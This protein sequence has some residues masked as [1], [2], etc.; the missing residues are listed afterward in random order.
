MRRRYTSAQF[1]DLIAVIY[2]LMPDAGLTCDVIVGF[3]G[4]TEPQF[5]ETVRLCE[6]A[7]FLKIHAFPYSQRTGTLAARM[8]DDV[9]PAEKQR[10]VD[11]LLRL[12]ERQGLDF[13]SRFAGETVSVLVEQRDR[14]TGQL[15]GLTG[16]YLRVHFDGPDNLRGHILPV[17]IESVAS[18]GAAGVLV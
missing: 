17:Q 9:P 12:S 11:V 6:E 8:E 15:S 1:R 3:P 10:R 14:A 16:N 2:K 5:E 18:S 4:E 13:A 7:R